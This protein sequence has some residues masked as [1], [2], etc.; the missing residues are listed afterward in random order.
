M[1]QPQRTGH[2]IV[3]LDRSDRDDVVLA[4]ALEHARHTASMVCVVHAIAPDAGV[5]AVPTDVSTSR[6]RATARQASH[7]TAT[8]DLRRHTTSTDRL[9]EQL[10]VDYD[11]RHGDPATVLLAA[12][13]QADLIVIGTHGTGHRSP[14]LLGTVSQDIAVH[15]TCPVLLIPTA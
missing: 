12:A 2:I 11:V 4:A 9:G 15:A 7:Q 5:V 8:E 6:D 3:G 1:T 10:T 13:R 14:L